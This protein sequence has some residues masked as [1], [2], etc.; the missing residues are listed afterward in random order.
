MTVDTDDLPFVCVEYPGLD[1]LLGD[2]HEVE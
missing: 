1:V 2:I